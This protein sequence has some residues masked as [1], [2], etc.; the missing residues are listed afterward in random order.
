MPTFFMAICGIFA[1]KV[2]LVL[3]SSDFLCMHSQSNPK[4]REPTCDLFI[5]FRLWIRTYDCGLYETYF[6]CR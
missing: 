1:S 4:P 5:Y 6:S 3:F 2:P